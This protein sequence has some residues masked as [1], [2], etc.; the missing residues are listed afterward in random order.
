MDEFTV[1][2]VATDP[3][4]M[5]ASIRVTITAMDDDDESPAITGDMTAMVAENAENQD[6]TIDS[7]YQAE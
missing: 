6:L 4:G 2:V 5:S 3:A 1:D 7:T